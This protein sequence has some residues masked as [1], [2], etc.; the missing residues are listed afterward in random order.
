VAD[1][2]HGM[3][4][5]RQQR[6]RLVLAAA[7]WSKPHLLA[8]DEPTNYLDNDTLAALTH[9]LKSFKH[10]GVIVISHNVKFVNALVRTHTCNY[11]SP[12]LTASAATVV[13][14]SL[15]TLSHVWL[16]RTCTCP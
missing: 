10:G 13:S 8:L 6:S 16:E 3:L 1:A 5:Q 12:G 15:A 2:D 4:H 7:M 14:T 11:R 9:A